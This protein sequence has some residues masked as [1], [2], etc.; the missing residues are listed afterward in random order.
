MLDIDISI[1][2][3]YI[4]MKEK[5]AKSYARRSRKESWRGR[6]SSLLPRYICIISVGIPIY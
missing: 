2:L 3:T 5:S 4:R 1:A 6:I